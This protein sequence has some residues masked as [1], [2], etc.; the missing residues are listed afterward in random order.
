VITSRSQWFVS[1]TA[2]THLIPVPSSIGN[3]TDARPVGMQQLG[4]QTG[5]GSYE[6]RRE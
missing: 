1:L 2:D 5:A 3:H 4:F 6:T